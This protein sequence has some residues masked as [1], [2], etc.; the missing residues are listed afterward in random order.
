MRH[1]KP[2]TETSLTDLQG[3]RILLVH[4]DAQE[5]HR[6]S[7]A[8]S[9]AQFEVEIVTSTR[10]ARD[11]LLRG[12]LD[13]VILDLDLQAEDGL[14]FLE[15]VFGHQA[16]HHV[17]M[18][19][20]SS[21]EDSS[22]VRTCFERGVDGFIV[23]PFTVEELTHKVERTLQEIRSH[24]FFVNP[25]QAL[26]T[27]PAAVLSGHLHGAIAAYLQSTGASMD[28]L[29]RAM[30]SARAHAPSAPSTLRAIALFQRLHEVHRDLARFEDALRPEP[31][32]DQAT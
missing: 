4:S 3:S 15:E 28:H 31:P 23:K 2:M 30:A 19:V 12:D 5:A 14:Q 7:Q 18:L 16:Y 24:Q 27:W 21:R 10:Q 9:L 22:L 8:L 6:A 26:A 32:P 20:L 25:R 11:R 17:P 29:R 13:L 1:A